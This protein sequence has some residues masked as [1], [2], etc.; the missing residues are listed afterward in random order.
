MLVGFKERKPRL[1][2][3]AIITPLVGLLTLSGLIGLQKERLRQITD[4][5]T[6]AQH[7]QEKLRQQASLALLQKMPGGSYSNLTANWSFLQFLQ[8]FGDQ[9]ARSTT[10]YSLN[11]E[12]LATVVHHD[13]RFVD[14][15][16]YM[17]SAS[18]LYAGRP[19][20]T[21]KIMSQG[22]QSLSPE[23]R[24]S[25]WIW[26][27]KGVDELLFLNNSDDAKNSYIMG[28]NWAERQRPQ[29]EETRQVIDSAQKTVTFLERGHISRTVRISA[30]L[31][32][33]GNARN[34]VKLQRFIIRKVISL[35][36]KVSISPEGHL[37]VQMPPENNEQSTN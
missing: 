36:A 16:L 4:Q 27:Y 13:P 31:T 2:L 7:Q 1:R 30:W 33:L 28:A 24:Q 9:Q 8:Y 37:R 29:D 22:L 25:Y 10:G 32:L 17:S 15:Y 3:A 6:A 26:I 23:I 14:A 35:G 20:K 5:E 12:F 11:P 18:S 21:V 34:D 19:D